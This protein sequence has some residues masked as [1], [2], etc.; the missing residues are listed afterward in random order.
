[1]FL[2]SSLSVFIFPQLDWTNNLQNYTK[3]NIL[4]V[5]RWLIDSIFC[6]G[7]F[8][9]FF[10]PNSTERFKIGAFDV[11]KARQG[12]QILIEYFQ[13]FAKFEG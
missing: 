13:I 1:M 2:V 3:I 5:L 8:F 6:S 11:L 4:F 7:F 9:V 12:R 10:G